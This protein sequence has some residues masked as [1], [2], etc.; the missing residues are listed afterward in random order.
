MAT[1]TVA[2]M[3]ARSLPFLPPNATAPAELKFIPH[4]ANWLFNKIANWLF[5]NPPA[6]KR[7]I[8]IK[9]AECTSISVFTPVWHGLGTHGG[10]GGKA[11]RDKCD[12][13]GALQGG[14]VRVRASRSWARPAPRSEFFYL[15]GRAANRP[16]YAT[17]LFKNMVFDN[18]NV[19]WLDLCSQMKP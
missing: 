11:K 13:S 14:T 17:C 7:K 5:K 6:T 9:L 2:S 1:A 3:L 18:E 15:L 4:A 16:I 8:G 19:L 12:K 10:G